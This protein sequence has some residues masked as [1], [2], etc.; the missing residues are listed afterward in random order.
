MGKSPRAR[1]AVEYYIDTIL[2]GE[3]ETQ[4]S[5]AKKFGTTAQS[6]K[7]NLKKIRASI[8]IHD[9]YFGKA[10][11]ES[12]KQN[13]LNNKKRKSL[14]LKRRTIQ[15][16]PDVKEKFD[17]LHTRLGRKTHSETVEVLIG[18]YYQSK[19]L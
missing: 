16:K 5:V 17:D 13:I 11:M 3:W 14:G 12:L 9:H 2:R 4:S 19:N 6:I 8:T 1:K 7:N 10:D 15:L 18:Y